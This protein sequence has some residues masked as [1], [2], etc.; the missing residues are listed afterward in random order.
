[1]TPIPPQNPPHDQDDPS[2]QRPPQEQLVADLVTAAYHAYRRNHSARFAA[3]VAALLQPLEGDGWRAVVERSMSAYLRAAITHAW[4]HGW[5]PVDLLRLARRR[6][7]EPQVHLLTDA[8][9]AE[10]QAYAPTTIDPRWRDQ[11]AEAGARTWWPSDQTFL[12]ARSLLPNTDGSR[13]LSAAVDVVCLL[14]SLPPIEKLG[15]LPGTAHPP[16]PAA[17]PGT[18]D[19]GK[20]DADTRMLQRIRQLLA[21]AEATTS[22]SEAE[23][24]TAAAQERMA[25][26]SIDQAML[27]A[28]GP[29]TTVTPSG[30][31][32]GI[33]N[34]YEH[35]K[36]ALLQVIAG[37]NR[38]QAVWTQS[39]GFTT[40]IGFAADLDAV[41]TLFTSLR[42]QAVTAMTHAGT[43]EQTRTRR[44]RQSFLTAYAHRIGERL[45]EVVQAQTQAAIAGSS[46][47]NLLPVLASRERAVTD[48]VEQMFPTLTHTTTR[49]TIDPDGWHSGLAA[50]DLASLNTSR[51]LPPTHRGES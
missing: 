9:A 38:C 44:F 6:F 11:L 40:V 7:T 26:Y 34:P 33:E 37:A 8:I 18:D 12:R 41:E 49:T 42:I 5:Q 48:T 3:A 35:P 27:E 25:R 47:N 22:P 15:P 17:A 30:R 13:V 43:R 21:K 23:A 20:P 2:S 16:R 45:T 14:W 46:G 39:L 51:P 24:L 36:A 31:R 29:G 1:M 4:Q 19:G 28:T 50:A 10:L 32:I